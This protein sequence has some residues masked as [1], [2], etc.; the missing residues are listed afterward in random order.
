M[1]RLCVYC[2]SSLGVNDAFITAAEELGALLAASN[3][4]LVYG[5]ATKGLMGRIADTVLGAG[6]Q[7]TGVI[8]A[9]LHD[10]EI[11][12]EGLTKLH[13]V[14]SM[15]ERKS[16]MAV[17]SDGFVALPGGFGTVEEL[18]EVLTWGQLQFH[19]KPCGVLNVDG[20]FNPLLTFFDNARDKG[21]LKSVHRDMLLVADTPADLLNQFEHYSPPA[22]EKWHAG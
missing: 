19:S 15:H 4:G 6:G 18:I 14:D 20:Y 2:G 21:F 7:V 1:N 16:L 10:K 11:A 22:D 9:A 8:P 12:H 3:I 17:L 13:V 5:G